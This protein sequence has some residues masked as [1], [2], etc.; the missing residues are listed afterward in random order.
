MSAEHANPQSG[1]GD[2]EESPREES[3]ESLKRAVVIEELETV[4]QQ[5]D[6]LTKRLLSQSPLNAYKDEHEAITNGA[7][8]DLE[9][10]ASDNV[11][12]YR[13]SDEA[14]LRRSALEDQLV[15]PLRRV[16]L[17]GVVFWVL[18]VVGALSVLLG[19][20]LLFDW[21]G[22]WVRNMLNVLPIREFVAPLPA[23]MMAGFFL[24]L[25]AVTRILQLARK[26]AL[27]KQLARSLDW[28]VRATREYLD[29]LHLGVEQQLNAALSRVL[30]SSVTVP[31]RVGSLR[32][33]ETR[34]SE[35]IESRAVRNVLNFITDHEASA[36]GLAGQR[37]IGKTTILKHLA[38]WA[39]EEGG[40]AVVVT[41]PVL[42]E[43]ED[44]IRRIYDEFLLQAKEKLPGYPP[45]ETRLPQAW[46]LTP[47]ESVTLLVGVA[48][49]GCGV[50]LFTNPGLLSD[51]VQATAWG[52][53]AAGYVLIAFGLTPLLTRLRL[54]SRI[55]SLGKKAV[56]ASKLEEVLTKAADHL[57]WE[58]ERSSGDEIA[59]ELP[60][61]LFAST[62]SSSVK[63]TE[64]PVGRSE[65]AQ[66]F[67]QTVEEYIRHSKDVPLRGRERQPVL[68]CVDELDKIADSA[69]ALNLVNELKDLMHIEGTHFLLT[70]SE[71]ALRAFALRGV[72]VRDA[73]DSTF[74]EVFEVRGLEAVE[75]HRVIVQRAPEFP[76]PLTRFC[77]AWSLGVPRDLLRAA[78]HCIKV[79]AD[80]TGARR[81]LG[82]LVRDVVTTDVRDAV[83]AQFA[84]TG[85]VGLSEDGRAL[86]LQSLDEPDIVSMR[87]LL[88]KYC[89]Q[90]SE[91]ASLEWQALL[92]YLAYAGK[93]LDVF[94]VERNYGEWLVLS[95]AGTL[96][97]TAD[98]LVAQER[99][100][101]LI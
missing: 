26:S 76:P 23:F 54:R 28:E 85:A 59:A 58:M 95:S 93:V 44:M 17:R 55:G 21:S 97:E 34:R 83:T 25:S 62:R 77:H 47:A 31:V 66:H 96:D 43:P 11:A 100:S 29:R 19:I 48:T 72:P 68:I 38:Q 98:E 69:G 67:R 42:Y 74:D 9:A 64:R 73:V 46:A 5:V 101:R 57:R 14:T 81:Q 99:R 91:A 92:G 87:E 18:L 52:L 80:Q 32:L 71:D 7:R 75:S 3:D 37:G 51:P 70:V 12:L 4:R 36:L 89:P 2:V 13:A 50:V 10:L 86:L 49:T 45:A 24:V 78:R 79:G 63:Q 15:V 90:P 16:H 65:L 40:L 94:G 8:E 60:A 61:K 35:V 22:T 53:I 84:R 88:V 56:V 39:E 27:L 1:G 82:A 41:A 6:D 20:L 30:E 33:V